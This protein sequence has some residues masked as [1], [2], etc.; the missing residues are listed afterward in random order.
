MTDDA[1]LHDQCVELL[2]SY[3][4]ESLDAGTAATV[5]AH[6]Q[7]C[8]DCRAEL[9]LTQSL[10]HHFAQRLQPMDAL[11][12]P[13]RQQA[14][15]ERLWAR[16]Q[17]QS[18][19]KQPAWRRPWAWPAMAAALL[20]AI[21]LPRYLEP[22]TATYRTLADTPS[23]ENCGQLRAQFIDQVTQGELQQLLG[24]VHARIV[25]GPS[26]RGVYTLSAA[27]PEAALQQLR[28]NPA[29]LLAE[30]TGC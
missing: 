28:L 29:V 10:H 30:P 6:L 15:F 19:P 21:F 25:D 3:V 18:L 5:T 4:D 1:L 26:N 27:Q 16:I 11:R 9:Q 22:V 12:D 24:T 14:N 8:A 2:S 20:L 17:V 23:R 13:V 7:H